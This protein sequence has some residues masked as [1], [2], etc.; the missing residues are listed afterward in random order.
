MHSSTPTQISI[1]AADQL[2]KFHVIVTLVVVYG[3][4][5]E[6]WHWGSQKSSNLSEFKQK[7]WEGRETE[8]EIELKTGDED[9]DGMSCG[10]LIF[11]YVCMY[12]C[13]CVCY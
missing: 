9:G 8:I 1:R 10:M 12:V 4:Y 5:C 13:V 6:N 11:M 2:T 3:I 7:Y